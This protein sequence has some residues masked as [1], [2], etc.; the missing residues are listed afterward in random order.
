MARTSQDQPGLARTGQRIAAV[1]ECGAMDT[2]K[3]FEMALEMGSGWKVVKSEMDVGMRQLKIWLDF[4]ADSQ[5]ECPE[6]GE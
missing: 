2:N 4:G 6:G 5:F 1:F 3:L